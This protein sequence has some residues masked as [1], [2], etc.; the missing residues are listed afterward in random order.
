MVKMNG[1]FLLQGH[2]SIEM[3][4]VQIELLVMDIGRP[5]ELTWQSYP[6]RKLYLGLGRHLF[7]IEENLQR[8]TRQIGLCMNIELMI[9][10]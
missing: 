5:L 8:V 10:L 1:T 9:L 3:E 2:G 4:T 7:S 6:M